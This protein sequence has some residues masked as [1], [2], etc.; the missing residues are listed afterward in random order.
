MPWKKR[1]KMETLYLMGRQQHGE[2]D[3]AFEA[4]GIRA[5]Y[6]SFWRDLLHSNIF[7]SFTPDLLHQLHKGTEHKEMEKVFLGLVAAGA[8]PELVHAVRALM[9]FASLASLQSHTT[10]TLLTL[11]ATLD[12]FHTHKNIFIELGRHKE[13]FNIP[14]IHSLEH[15]EPSIRL[16]GS[17]EG[18]NTESPECLHID[19]AKN[20][21]W[22][23]NR[24]DYIVQMTLWLQR[25]ESVARFSAFKEW[26]SH[27]TSGHNSL[28]ALGFEIR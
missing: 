26:I 21:Y 18:F 13:H 19:Y 8:H 3:S 5:V 17:A 20:A 12:D 1:D 25:Q 28:G 11:R 9:D 10:T 22:A 2:K 6:P 14:K 16:F 15:Y 4:E 27:P 7:Q 24:K 23:S